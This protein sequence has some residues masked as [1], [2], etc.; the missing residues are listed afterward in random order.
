ML[1]VI[2]FRL[3]ACFI[4][5]S[6]FSLSFIYSQVSSDTIRTGS[7]YIFIFYNDDEITGK[8]T[9]Q[10]SNSIFL[11]SDYG[12]VKLKR[13]NIY[14][15]SGNIL[16]KKYEAVFSLG[17]GTSYHFEKDTDSPFED[18][19]YSYSMQLSILFPLKGNRGLRADIGYASQYRGEKTE[20]KYQGVFYPVIGSQMRDYFSIKCDYVFG[21]I[22]PENKLWVYGTAGIGFN[23]VHNRDNTYSK[24]EE[25]YLFF[26]SSK[27]HFLYSLGC[28]VGYRLNEHFGIYADSQL[29]FYGLYFFFRDESGTYM[30]L[31]A[32]VTYTFY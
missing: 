1:N 27:F 3:A 16:K 8:V 7:S 29:D 20:V 25:S 6:I 13:N 14:T 5:L 18:F 15:F 9:G 19:N 28:T 31:R 10:D 12:F 2:L 23:F 22:S 26:G 17:G 32:G 24:A 30:P 4:L 21:S 11:Y